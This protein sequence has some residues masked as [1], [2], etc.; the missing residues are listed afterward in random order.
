[1]FAFAESVTTGTR[2]ESA[3]NGNEEKWILSRLQ[4]CISETTEA[5]D[6]LRVREAV[7][8]ALFELEQDLSWYVRRATARSAVNNETVKQVL[9]IRVRLMAPVTPFICEEIWRMM[10]NQGFV[11]TAPWPHANSS[12]IDENVEEKENLIRATLEDISDIIKTTGMTPKSLYLYVAAEWKWALYGK[13]LEA[14]S[15]GSAALS[16]LMKAASS[17]PRLNPRM[18]EVSK[19]APKLAKDMQSTAQN[20]REKR[21]RLGKV[22]E[23][24]ALRD[25]A[26][27]LTKELKCEVVVFEES[28]DR[29]YDPKGRAQAAQPFRPAI[30][31]E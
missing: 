27:L 17:D 16:E 10:G 6:R 26:S 13:A 21:Q 1:M 24:N 18:K 15:K 3:H 22:D 7:H 4:D 12:M 2:S 25:A 23:A 30:Y 29:K 9:D 19:L 5:M 20:L 14:A 31:L 11:S 28:D 8:H